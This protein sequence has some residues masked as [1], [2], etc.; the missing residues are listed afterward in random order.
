MTTPPRHQDQK[1]NS[2]DPARRFRTERTVGLSGLTGLFLAAP[3]AGLAALA[4][5][6]M[7]G[8]ETFPIGPQRLPMAYALTPVAGLA[9]FQL[10]FGMLTGRWRGGRYWLIALPVSALIWGTG[11]FLLL[12]GLVRPAPLLA[13]QFAAHTAAAGLAILRDGSAR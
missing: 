8:G 5:L 7:L 1:A 6:L 4:V 13:G 9:V 12:E 2:A 11:L 10:V 3:A